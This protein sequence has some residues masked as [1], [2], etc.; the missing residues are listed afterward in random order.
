[1]EYR[2]FGTTEKMLS[3][4][5][6]GGMR[7]L[8]ADDSPRDKVPEDTLSQCAYAVKKALECG[9]NHIETAYGYGK[10]EH[11]LGIAV[12]DV[13]K[14][15]R[16]A[17]YLMTKGAPKTASETRP[18]VEQQLKALKTSYFDFY[19]WHGINNWGRFEMACK[20]KGPV[21]E[22]LKMKDEGIIGHVG[23][24]THA[25]LDVIIRSIE[26]RMFE[27]V[28]L[29]YYYFFQRNYAAI[30]LAQLKDMG[31]L[32]ISPNDKGGQLYNAPEK[33]KSLTTPLTPIQWNARFCLGS[34]AVHTLSFGITEP[35]QFDE[36]TGIFPAP[37]PMSPDDKKIL[38]EMDSQQ[39][40]DPYS[41][42]NGYDMANDPSGI[43]IPEV[44]RLRKLW[45]CYNMID[46][47]RYRYNLFEE[48]H[49]WFPG[50]PADKT[51]IEKINMAKV[52]K[53]IPL[54]EILLEAHE[55]FHKKDNKTLRYI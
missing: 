55:A 7:F 11:A 1:M 19:A 46:F 32:I 21:E 43:N 5:T 14:I 40:N 22:L 44:L 41:G 10:S 28:N 48:H 3:T 18:L 27:F 45:K 13:L 33:L 29:H 9:I 38:L 26:T 8:H 39:L 20:K 24:S 23:F 47:C 17:Y 53:N 34:P 49:H 37:V 16:N 50:K 30:A 12:N 35:A 4:I 51:N 15:R 36:M 2:R 31:V 52:P 25:P 6:L 54:K 42:Y